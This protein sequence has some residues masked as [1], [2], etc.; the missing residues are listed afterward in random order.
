MAETK[1]TR[2][3]RLT[4]G[5][6][7]YDDFNGVYFTIQSLRMH[8]PEVIDDVEFLV[9][10]NHPDGAEG[11]TVRDLVT[12]WLPGAR[13]VAAPEAVGTSAPRELLFRLAEGEAVL[14][15]DC[16]VLL[17]PGAVRRLLEFYQANPACRDLLHG[18]LL[19]DNGYV[20]ATHMDPVWRDEMLGVW[21][22]DPRGMS[23]DAAPF[24]VPMHGCGLMSCRKDAWLGFHP[25][26]RGFG[27]EE[28]YIHEKFRRA[29]RRVLCLPFL[30]WLHR[31]GRPQGVRY[32]LVREN[33]IRN[34]LLGRVELGLPYEDV[35][36]HF[37][38]YMA[39]EQMESILV[40]LGLPGLTEHRS[41][42]RPAGHAAEGRAA[43]S[44]RGRPPGKASRWRRL[45]RAVLNS[46]IQA[47]AR[48][49]RSGARR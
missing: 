19:Y 2:R 27:G 40:E 18:P 26:F 11:Q 3:P 23:A 48:A 42:S 25:Q 38:P 9:V 39:R 5:M 4:I 28:G 49:M 30:R 32:P 36:H 13:Y 1:P 35:I 10:D 14:C 33:R 31:F 7:C 12:N 43:T 20:A 16:H 24:E 37:A 47:L 15:L 46:P 29:G 21:G 44:R 45:K 41:P 6:A 34:Y 22:V 17:A 8:H